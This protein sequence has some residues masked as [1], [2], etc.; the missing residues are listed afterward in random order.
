MSRFAWQAQYFRNE[1]MLSGRFFVAGT[2]LWTG[3]LSNLVADAALC[4]VPKVQ[5]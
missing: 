3:V 2:A 1:S 4:D 5:F